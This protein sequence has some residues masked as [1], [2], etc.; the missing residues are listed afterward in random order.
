M[1]FNERSTANP[2]PHVITQLSQLEESRGVDKNSP[3]VQEE[4]L[5]P[6]VNDGA[7]KTKWKNPRLPTPRDSYPRR[8]LR[9]KS[10]ADEEAV[11]AEAF[12]AELEPMTLE[13]VLES[14]DASKWLEAINSELNSLEE[15]QTWV[16]V[17]TGKNI[18]TNRWV[19]RRKF[20]TDGQVEKYKARLVWH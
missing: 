13:D 1:I 2:E 9:T 5:N 19:F 18:I 4:K 7:Q 20:K 16:L 3:T 6:E 11:I 15:N 12:L 8:N 17:P 10:T 14:E